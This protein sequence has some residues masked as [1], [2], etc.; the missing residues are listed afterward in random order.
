M[1]LWTSYS[2]TEWKDIQISGCK[3]HSGFLTQKIW[4]LEVAKFNIG[5]CCMYSSSCCF[6]FVGFF[7]YSVIF[8][9]SLLF[10]VFIYSFF[11]YLLMHNNTSNTTNHDS[12]SFVSQMFPFVSRSFS[13]CW[14]FLSIVVICIPLAMMFLFWKV[15]M[16]AAHRN[17]VLMTFSTSV[18]R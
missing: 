5:K 16:F 13:W 18:P 6:F 7:W 12:V 9:P 8:F 10:Y 15:E 3:L 14:K 4:S 1:S 2:P 11:C 17:L